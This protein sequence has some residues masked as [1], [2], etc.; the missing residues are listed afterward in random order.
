MPALAFCLEQPQARLI[1]PRASHRPCPSQ[2]HGSWGALRV[3][4]TAHLSKVRSPRYVPIFWGWSQARPHAGQP[5]KYI[6]P[7]LL[8]FLLFSE[9]SS[10]L[11]VFF[12]KPHIPHALH[13]VIPGSFNEP[14]QKHGLYR[15]LAFSKANKCIKL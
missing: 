3:E 15:G 14:S 9:V 13:K 5:S 7:S 2:R 1:T 4:L 11:A 6:S 8:S 10:V 12:D